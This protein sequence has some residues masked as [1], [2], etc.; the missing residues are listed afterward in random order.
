M[1]IWP[2]SLLLV[3]ALAWAS[4]YDYFECTAADGTVSYSVERC[5][6][7]Q[8]QRKVDDDAAPTSLALGAA[9]GATVR[10][11]NSRNGHFFT[12]VKINGVPLRALVDTGATTV[13]ITPTAAM[14]VGVDTRQGVRTMAYTANGP[15]RSIGIKFASVDLGGN[16]IRNVAGS[17][18][19]GEMGP[20]VEVLLGMSFLKHFE[21]NTDG[22]VMTLR[23]K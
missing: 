1:R 11:E 6:K 12:T 23:P 3:P 19:A 21:V 16:T 9:S 20:N 10:L 8:Q 4:S 5:P 13:A 18:V 14:R 17:L 15:I 2:F 22:L 7:G